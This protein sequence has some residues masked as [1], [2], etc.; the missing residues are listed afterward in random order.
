MFYI[1]YCKLLKLDIHA[2]GKLNYSFSKIL[3]EIY[4]LVAFNV[5]KKDSQISGKLF[6]IVLNLV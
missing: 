6:P 2:M 4:Y 3:D 1:I 5:L